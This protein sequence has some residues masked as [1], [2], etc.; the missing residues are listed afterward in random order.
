MQWIRMPALLMIALLA[1]AAAACGTSPDEGKPE[2]SGAASEHQEGHSEHD[3]GKNAPSAP[4][5]K[6]DLPEDAKAGKEVLIQITVTHEGEPVNDADEVQFEI[7][8]KGAPKDDHEMIDAEKTGDGV[9]SIKK[10]FP[11][12]GEYKVM[13]HVTARGSHVMEPAETLVVQ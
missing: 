2:Q 9:Y 10:T 7:W 1:F 6:M 5:V 11:E 12:P 3:A 8:K 4:K 13:Y